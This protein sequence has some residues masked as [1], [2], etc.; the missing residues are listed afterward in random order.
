MHYAELRKAH[1]E[2]TGP[3]GDF[4]I[5]RA[6]ILG[7]DILTYRNAP[8]SIREFWLSTLQFADRPYLIYR[9]ER[10]TYAQSHERTAAIAAWLFA[11][12]VKPGD[13]IALS[14]RNYPEWMLIYWACASVGIT[15]VGMNA[16]WTAEEMAYAL[17]DSAPKVLFLDQERLERHHIPLHLLCLRCA[18]RAKANHRD[19]AHQ[20]RNAALPIFHSHIPRLHDEP[21]SCIFIW[22]VSIPL[23]W[24]RICAAR[25]HPSAAKAALRRRCQAARIDDNCAPLTGLSDLVLDIPIVF[26]GNHANRHVRA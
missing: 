22:A 14:M 15:V 4:E 18:R 25:S 1:E 8:P 24:P 11:Q 16:W 2:L 10:L 3:G 9:D 5:I 21:S 13:R 17:A 7:N 26:V 23:A 19:A 12:G 6:E 20:R